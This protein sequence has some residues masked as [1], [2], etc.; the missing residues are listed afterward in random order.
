M[1]V[2]EFPRGE[3]ARPEPSAANVFEHFRRPRF[4]SERVRE[5][6]LRD[7]SVVGELALVIERHAVRDP[8]QPGAQRTRG[9]VVIEFAV[10]DEEDIVSE[11]LEV[12]HLDPQPAKGGVDIAQLCFVNLTKCFRL[13][14]H[15][16]SESPLD[17]SAPGCAV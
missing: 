5:V 17:R 7:L 9:V 15:A 4:L 8:E 12:P 10:D 14:A 11:I 13:L 2:F 6:I 1:S 3:Q 16:S